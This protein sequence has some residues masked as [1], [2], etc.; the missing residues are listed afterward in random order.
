MMI[1]EFGTDGYRGII[2]KNYTYDILERLC[3]ATAKW[4][5]EK[6]ITQNGVV[7]GY[8]TRFGGKDFT[9]F[10]AQVLA[11]E[12]LNV[13]VSNQHTTTPAVSFAAKKY[14]RV[15]I[16]IT[17]SHNPPS[18]NGYK[19]K[20]PFGGPAFL[21]QI[22]EVESHC[23]TITSHTSAIES[24]E[25]YVNKKNRIAFISLN[26]EYLG[27]LKHVVDIDLISSMEGKVGHDAMYGSTQ[28]QLSKLLGRD[29]VIEYRSEINPLFGGVAPEPI[30]KNLTNFMEGVKQNRLIAGI[31]NDGDGD[32]IGMV[33]NNGE[34]VSSHLVMS[35]LLKYL[36]EERKIKGAVCKT[37]AATDMLD[38]QAKTY[39]IPCYVTPIGFKY[40]TEY[41]LRE[42][43]IIGG[44][45]S[46]GI[47]A[48]GHIP[49][50]DG[51]YIGL[52]IL[53]MLARTKKTLAE[54]IEQLYH[55]F[56]PHYT[57]RR[58]IQLPMEQ[59]EQFISFCR[60]KQLKTV[61]SESVI[62]WDM[63][64]GVKHR[65]KNGWVMVRASGTEPI[66]RVYSEASSMDQAI[67]M[68][69][70]VVKKAQAI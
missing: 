10:A 68:V 47:S 37:F 59:K 39:G 58:D 12:G 53:E 32:R 22:Q 70:E 69:E 56:G 45:E 14:N 31:A 38:K 67:E 64:D 52:L 35:L 25:Y 48:F 26:D 33:D 9:L 4:I 29:K 5:I 17:A 41:L 28:G 24:L 3:R 18:Y 44:E 43:V 61:I 63:L 49:E 19:L 16:V 34:Y 23:N 40:V 60:N 57:Y 27:E 11:S 66:L 50:R 30:E 65:L 54:S 15:G 51:L 20:A 13:L 21:S 7:I 36:Y 42:P 6:N 55:E 8:D 1:I 46:G 62:E 2:A